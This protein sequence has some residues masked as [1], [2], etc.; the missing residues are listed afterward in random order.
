M[1][2]LAA[3]IR[4][5]GT[6]V[7]SAPT[8]VQQQSV[9]LPMRTLPNHPYVSAASGNASPLVQ[10]PVTSTVASLPTQPVATTI[11]N[12]HAV[13]IGGQQVK[14]FIYKEP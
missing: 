8:G 1:S 3:A 10:S 5:G 4:K 7:T 11:G 13:K 6:I 2:A 9:V 14:Y 12:L